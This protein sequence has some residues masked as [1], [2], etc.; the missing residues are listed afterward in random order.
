[1][2]SFHAVNCEKSIFW[3][4]L[5]D[6]VKPACDAIQPIIEEANEL[7]FHEKL[8]CDSEKFGI[9]FE[10]LNVLLLLYG[11]SFMYSLKN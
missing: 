7:F 5:H 10:G 4:V 2:I 8:Y 3:T 1:M 6:I 9:T 11:M